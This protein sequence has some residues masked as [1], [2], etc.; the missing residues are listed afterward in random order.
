MPRIDKNLISCSI[1]LYRSV[2]EART[3]YGW[4][5]SGFLLGM[6]ST[7]HP[8]MVHLYAVTNEHVVMD[9]PVIRYRD[10]EPVFCA[11]E[12]WIAHPS[13]DDLAIRL[14]GLFPER[15]QS[16]V[17]SDLILTCREMV[18]ADIAFGDECVMI[19]RFIAPNGE[20]RAQPVVRFGNLSM[21][22]E[23][24][25][26]DFRAFNQ[27]SFL[28]DMRSL[29]GFSGSPVFVYWITPGVMSLVIP[30]RREDMVK[31][32]R[33]DLMGEKWLLGIDWGHM[34]LTQPVLDES[35]HPVS[36]GWR[37]KVNTG[38]ATVVPAWKLLDLLL[39]T[40]EVVKAREQQDKEQSKLTP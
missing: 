35:G 18:V 19:G 9:T 13:G 26:Q 21:F 31:G 12:D 32:P 5:G 40:E 20:Q 10:E 34:P 6:R 2:E 28:V 1:F 4:G 39:D 15:D 33:R 27:E 17:D 8:A 36:E 3:G 23:P 7:V 25:F 11:C 30:P 38:I 24:I 29:S 14:L 37:F 22:P 16:F